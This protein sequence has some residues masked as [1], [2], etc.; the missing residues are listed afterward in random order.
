MKSKKI[1]ND[2]VDLIDLI[3]IIF[4]HKWKI[5]NVT[6]IVAVLYSIILFFYNK[7]TITSNEVLLEIQTISSISENKYKVFNKYIDN[8]PAAKNKRLESLE[9]L[10][11][12]EIYKN[13]LLSLFIEELTELDTVENVIKK[14]DLISKDKNLK[15]IASTFQIIEIKKI[16]DDKLYLKISFQGN[17]KNVKSFLSYIEEY[18]NENIRLNLINNFNAIIATQR[19]LNKFKI[20]DLEMQANK[21]LNINQNEIERKLIYLE[22]QAEIARSLGIVKNINPDFSQYARSLYYMR[23]YEVLEKEIEIIKNRNNSSKLILTKKLQ[24]LNYEKQ[25]L[26]KSPV[27]QRIEEIFQETPI[28]DQNNFY[29]ARITNSGVSDIKVYKNELIDVFIIAVLTF[30]CMIFYVLIL[31]GIQNRR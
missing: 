4:K 13:S 25:M 2:D 12:F 20:E 5:V 3:L 28:T 27:L 17:K 22:E 7:N 15:K 8:I 21:L 24:K 26:E 9:I 30:V 10:S 11:S 23:G 29:A 16:E 6:I 18:V 14:Y 31:N 19:K 1:T